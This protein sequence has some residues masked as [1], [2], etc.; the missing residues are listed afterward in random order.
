MALNFSKLPKRTGMVEI[1]MAF[2]AAKN[3]AFYRDFAPNL[4]SHFIPE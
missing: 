1:P 4:C 3:P 2:S